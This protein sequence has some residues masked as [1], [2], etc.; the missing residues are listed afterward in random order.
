MLKN[1]KPLTYVV[2]K[3]ASLVFVVKRDQLKIRSEM[4]GSFSKWD[5]LKQKA[6]LY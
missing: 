3:H 1:S 5:H 4:G 2:E 6:C